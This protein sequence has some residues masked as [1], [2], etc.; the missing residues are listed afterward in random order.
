LKLKKIVLR[1]F[2][3]YEFQQIDFSDKFNYIFGEN[4]SGKTN[5]LEAVSLIAFGKSF[6][7]SPEIDC[8][9]F[10][11][12][13]FTVEGKFISR[14]DTEFN[15]GLQY[16]RNLKKKNFS[17]NKEKVSGFSSELFGKF[18]TVFMSPHS[19]NITYGNPSERRRFFDIIISQVSG[20]Y[21]DDMRVLNRLLK[22]KNALLK[23][24]YEA[25]SPSSGNIKEMME[26]YNVKLA[27]VSADITFRR[28]NFLK[29]FIVFFKEN[30]RELIQGDDEPEIEY[31]SCLEPDENLLNENETDKETLR[32]GYMKKLNNIYSDELRRGISLAGPHRDDF[33][34]KIKK[35]DSA[36]P[37]N[38]K[39]FAS[40][41]EHKTYMVGLKL[42]EYNYIR[43]KLDVNPIMLLDDIL[44]ELDSS[45]VES[46]MSHLN[47]F[48][49]IFLTTTQDEY[50]KRL[51][52]FF[53]D[54][55]IKLFKVENSSVK[56]FETI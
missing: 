55:N 20:L 21:L 48:G 33:V 12:E 9:R 38:I 37:F 11:Q 35:A 27:A 54:K 30:F 47:E 2:R 1:N 51:G 49:Q 7:S 29:D 22:L 15:V 41:G 52:T 31:S 8:L 50:A 5:I 24:F 44:S 6:L 36:Q 56:T 26:V 13:D 53:T 39:N 43:S 18:P 17:L 10:G 42:A 25:G 19:L 34:F 3:N 23:N 16:N 45:R 4:G 14:L 40:Q 28:L 32:I 46:I